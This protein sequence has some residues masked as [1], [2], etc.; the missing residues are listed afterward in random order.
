M[1]MLVLKRSYKKP[2]P[3]DTFAYTLGP[4]PGKFYFGRVIRTDSSVGPMVNTTLIY[5]YRAT[6]PKKNEIPI[7]SP[8]DL[9]VGPIH[10][11][12]RPWSMGYFEKVGFS[13]LRQEDLLPVHCFKDY[14][15]GYYYDADSNPLPGPVEPMGVFGLDSFRTIDIAVSVALGLPAESAGY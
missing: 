2:V 8:K 15:P 7:L 10:T 6:S 12:T 3:G 4:F 5:L 14:R 11:N 1:N 13:E 9:L